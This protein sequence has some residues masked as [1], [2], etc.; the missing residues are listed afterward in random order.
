MKEAYAL[1]ISH[2]LSNYKIKV[3]S[4]KPFPDYR[5]ELNPPINIIINKNINIEGF[6]LDKD[7]NKFNIRQIRIKIIISDSH[8]QTVEAFDYIEPTDIDQ[9]GK[10]ITEFNKLLKE[11]EFHE[12]EAINIINE[13]LIT[14]SCINSE[15]NMVTTTDE[16]L[17]KEYHNSITQ[18]KNK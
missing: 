16:K 15:W 3:I 12:S 2:N 1:Y 6:T 8:W 14:Y 18:N 11:N 4:S 5:I 9:K 17:I 7:N 13:K 10:I